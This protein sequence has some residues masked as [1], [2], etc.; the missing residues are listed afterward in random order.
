MT[1]YC[2]SLD[3]DCPVASQVPVFGVLYT[4]TQRTR[5]NSATMNIL[6]DSTAV[7]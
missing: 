2:P 5:Y 1:S 3:N 6:L 4:V 7:G